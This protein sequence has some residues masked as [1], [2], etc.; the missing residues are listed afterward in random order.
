MIFGARM[1]RVVAIMESNPSKN[2]ADINWKKL[3]QITL[4]V[5]S[6]KEGLL[7]FFVYSESFSREKV[8]AATVYQYPR[9]KTRK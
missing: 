8:Y 7:A 4:I 5:F 9:G 1:L 3:K 6:R 2:P